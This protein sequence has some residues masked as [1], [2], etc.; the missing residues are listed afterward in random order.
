N[1]AVAIRNHQGADAFFGKDPD[2]IGQNFVRPERDHFVALEFQNR[3]HR[4]FR[5]P[6]PATGALSPPAS[7]PKPI[8]LPRAV[9]FK[10]EK[11]WENVT[12]KFT[13]GRRRGSGFVEPA[14]AE[15]AGE[16]AADMS[17]PGNRVVRA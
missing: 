13:Q 15:E 2:R 1:L 9:V 16:E 10:P 6:S 8:V 4:H 11:S 12:S 3:L 7:S 5:P 14:D 17:L